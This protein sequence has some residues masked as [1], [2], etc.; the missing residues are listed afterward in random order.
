[1]FPTVKQ[2]GEEPLKSYDCTKFIAAVVGNDRFTSQENPAIVNTLSRRLDHEIQAL[3]ASSDSRYTRAQFSPQ[4]IE[5]FSPDR[6]G[7]VQCRCAL[8]L[9]AVLMSLAVSVTS[10]TE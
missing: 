1:M 9:T 10:P 7:R 2:S 3:S 8:I 6:L 5:Q 4:Y